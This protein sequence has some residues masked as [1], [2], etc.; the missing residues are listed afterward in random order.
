MV[1]Q[2]DNYWRA[3]SSQGL[4]SGDGAQVGFFP[5]LDWERTAGIPDLPLWMV[6]QWVEAITGRVGR[7][8]LIVYGSDWVPGFIE[9]RAENPDIAVW[10]ANYNTGDQPSGGWAESRKYNAAFWQFTDH[11]PVPGFKAPV[12]GN[13]IL[14]RDVADRLAGYTPVATEAVVTP[15]PIIINT[16]HSTQSRKQ[17]DIMG[18]TQLI[19]R[20]K[21]YN[22]AFLIPGDYHVSG[23]M[24]RALGTAGVPYVDGDEDVSAV[25]A[26]AARAGVN[27][28]PSATGN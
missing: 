6:D 3:L 27:M 25:S 19:I 16:P 5:Q 7:D 21:G 2:V 20:A 9:W 10:Y 13:M 26:I 23:A 22:E 4:V 14:R 12:D 18:T 1:Q 11:Y 8:R 28:T 15:L 24:L 17:D